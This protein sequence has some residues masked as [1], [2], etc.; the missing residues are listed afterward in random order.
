M[1][2]GAGL[3]AHLEGLDDVVDLDVVERPQ[4][5]AALE[6]FPHLGRVVLEA[7]QRLDGEVVGD[8]GAV[9]HQASLGVAPDLAA[10]HEAAGDVA[11]LA[12]AVDLADLG[13]AELRLFVLGLEHALER[14]LDL[15]DRLVDHRVVAN[16]DALAVDQVA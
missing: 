12:R 2:F 9:A 7:T 16:V 10:A 11:E 6:A 8:D 14:R 4:A 5:D 3:L 1:L 15:V 13:G